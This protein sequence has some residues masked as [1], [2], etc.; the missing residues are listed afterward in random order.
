MKLIIAGGRD[1]QL[2]SFDYQRLDIIHRVLKLTEVVSGKARGADRCGEIW[3]AR[4]NV[5]IKPFPADWDN[6]GKRA[7]FIR[8]QEMAAYADAVALFP[9][10]RGTNNMYDEACGRG[11]LI[12]DFRVPPK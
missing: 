7:G 10:G 4:N 5:P 12:Y 2:N 1:Y 6:L 11:L 9:G 8:N 3:A